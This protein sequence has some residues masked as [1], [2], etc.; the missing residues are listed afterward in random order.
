[1]AV[2]E[3]AFTGE[4]APSSELAPAAFSAETAL[5]GD[6]TVL[7]ELFGDPTPELV[8]LEGDATVLIERWGERTLALALL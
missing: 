3:S 1:M 7:V 2:D 8:A 5:L 4:P 6:A